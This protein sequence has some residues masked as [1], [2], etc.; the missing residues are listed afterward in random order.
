MTFLSRPR[1]TPWR[2]GNQASPLAAWR[3]AADLVWARWERVREAGREQRESAFR[4]Y[5]D[6]LDAEAAA[7][8]ALAY[9]HM[10]NAG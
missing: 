3:S 4:A 9:N 6:A 10:H 7:A 8:E 2:G 1:T 5:L